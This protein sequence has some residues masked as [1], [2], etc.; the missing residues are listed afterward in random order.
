MARG[1]KSTGRKPGRP[2]KT[3]V[4]MVPAADLTEASQPDTPALSRNE[5]SLA[6]FGQDVLERIKG[7]DEVYLVTKNEARLENGAQ[8]KQVHRAE[9]LKEL[10]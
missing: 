6:R 1:R 4:V 7:C 9:W 2:R 8:D 5:T 3:P 10:A